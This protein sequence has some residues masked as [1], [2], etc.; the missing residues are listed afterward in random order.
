[1]RRCRPDAPDVMRTQLEK[2]SSSPPLELLE[3]KVNE[4]T[5]LL[6]RA[7]RTWEGTFDAIVD[8]LAIE[9]RDAGLAHGRLD[10]HPRAHPRSRSGGVANSSGSA[11]S[12]R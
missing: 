6:M 11:G 3:E 7:K 10:Q 9:P 2:T 1:M 5:R 12:G 8:P 4:R